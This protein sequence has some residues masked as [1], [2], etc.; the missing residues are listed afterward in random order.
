MKDDL[1]KQVVP[2]VSL[3]V[4]GLIFYGSAQLQNVSEHPQGQ[5]VQDQSQFTYVKYQGEEGRTA[6]DLL[7]SKYNVETKEFSGLG[8]F[9]ARINGVPV[10]TSKFFWGFY[11]NG[12]MS[13]VGAS[14]YVTKS[15][16][17]LEWKLEEINGN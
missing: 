5:A 8:E 2:I 9:V 6:V 3:L 4:V 16:D 14:Q 10:D 7:K 1:K 15:G 11:V 12:K 17:V 13:D